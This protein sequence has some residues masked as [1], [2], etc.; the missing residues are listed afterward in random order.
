MTAREMN[1]LIGTQVYL[2]AAPGLQVLC[3]V[4]NAKTVFGD[5]RVELAP[6]EGKGSAWVNV[7]RVV[8]AAEAYSAS[9]GT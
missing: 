8:P 2:E 1:P 3:E 9:E 6:V 7:S 4:T 5:A